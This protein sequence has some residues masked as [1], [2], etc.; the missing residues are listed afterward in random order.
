MKISDSETIEMSEM[1]YRFWEQKKL[2]ELSHEEWELLCDHCGKCCL[3]KVEDDESGKIYFTC[4]ACKL[5]DLE[6]G[7]CRDYEHRAQIVPDCIVLT[8]G[9]LD[10]I[11]GLPRTCAYRLLHEGK[12]L[13][14]WHP[15]VSGSVKTVR[16]AGMN[17][18]GFA[19]AEQEINLKHIK[20]FVLDSD[21]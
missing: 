11:N 12:A 19:I 6:S 16:E 13:P 9:K 20:G 15:L 1:Q 21:L 8:A 3:H 17:I 14:V 7:G 2:A 18:Q 4:V 5:Y 10:E